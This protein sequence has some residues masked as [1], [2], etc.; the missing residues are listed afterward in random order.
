[1]KQITFTRTDGTQSVV[2]VPDGQ[3]A[4]SA[5]ALWAAN[6]I[7]GNPVASYVVEDVQD[8]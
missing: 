2:V 5:V 6:E 8:A 7:A 4:Q 1:M 3:S